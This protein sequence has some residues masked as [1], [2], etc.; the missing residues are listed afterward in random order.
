MPNIAHFMGGIYP[1]LLKQLFGSD[2]GSESMCKRCGHH[3]GTVPASFAPI[4]NAQ[5]AKAN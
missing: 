4:F 2:S 3:A 1:G 5:E